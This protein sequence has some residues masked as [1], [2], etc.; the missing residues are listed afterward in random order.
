MH[1]FKKIPS[2]GII[3]L[4]IISCVFS[5][6]IT[7]NDHSKSKVKIVKHNNPYWEDSGNP[8]W[9]DS[10]NPYWVD[11]HGDSNKTSEPIAVQ[12]ANT[13]STGSSSTG[14]IEKEKETKDKN[15]KS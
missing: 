2:I 3:F 9:E 5:K 1:I 14:T 13:S 15:Q 6:V 10:G 12:V 11:T 8:Y 7:P 4:I